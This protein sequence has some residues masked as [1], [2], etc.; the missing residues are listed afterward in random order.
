MSKEEIMTKSEVLVPD[1]RLMGRSNSKKPPQ[2]RPYVGWTLKPEPPSDN[3]AIR[4][5][6]TAFGKRGKADL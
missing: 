6:A 1:I 3:A 2:K 5:D 4:P